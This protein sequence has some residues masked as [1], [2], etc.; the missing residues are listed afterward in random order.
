MQQWYLMYPVKGPWYDF[1][2]I[3]LRFELLCS[4]MIPISIKVTLDL[5]K[6]VYAKFIDWDEQM[7][8]WETNTPAHSAKYVLRY[9]CFL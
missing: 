4:I 3:P 5:A 8:D 1:L 2:V 6:G 7:F 9:I